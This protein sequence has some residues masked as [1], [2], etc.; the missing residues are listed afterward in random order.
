MAPFLYRVAG[1]PT[2]TTP[3]AASF[4]DVP[5]T[6]PFPREAE[7]MRASGIST[8]TAQ[9]T[10]APLYKP[11]DPVTRRAMAAFLHRAADR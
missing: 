3:T 8:G 4:A 11:V 1:S 6:R 2:F 5:T 7:W 9:P 10:G